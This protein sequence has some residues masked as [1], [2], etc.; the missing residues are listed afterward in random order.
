MPIGALL[1]I[2]GAA[3]AYVTAYGVL[4]LDDEVTARIGRQSQWWTGVAAIGCGLVAA[5]GSGWASRLL[6]LAG[7]LLLT[8]SLC[9]EGRSW[10][11]RCLMTV[12]YLCG[13]TG[14]W[15]TLGPA[16]TAAN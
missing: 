8:G 16:L 15:M 7:L 6:C 3:G 13:G 9:S 1:F 11:R 2:F 4:T 10:R 12:G 14:I 5:S